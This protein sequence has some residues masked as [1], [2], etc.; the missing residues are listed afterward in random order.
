[1][2]K[3]TLDKPLKAKMEMKTRRNAQDDVVLT[4]F[5]QGMFLIERAGKPEKVSLFGVAELRIELSNNRS[6][7]E[8][9]EKDSVISKGEAVDLSKV[10]E[11]GKIT[12]LHFHQ[13]GLVSSERQG[14]YVETL[15]KSSKGKI[16]LKRVVVPDGSAPVAKQLN[17][18]SF[19][20]FWFYGK[21]GQVAAK[22]TDRFTEQDINDAVKKASK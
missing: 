11:D 15:E 9:K 20:Q 7:N 4:G 19:P 12:I 21:N 14:N 2:K 17:M 8:L 5:E 3:L 16:V 18:T 6:M 22:L 10:P 1:V 13:P